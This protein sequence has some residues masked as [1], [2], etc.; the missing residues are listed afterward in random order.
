MWA[1]QKRGANGDLPTFF[2]LV[3]GFGF[4][5]HKGHDEQRNGTR[6]GAPRKASGASG[7]VLR[8]HSEKGGEV[9][10][11]VDSIAFSK[12]RSA[13]RLMAANAGWRA[14]TTCAPT[15]QKRGTSGANVA[16]A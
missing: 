10:D 12:R 14:A 8:Q 2:V 4:D 16:R 11:N 3:T 7:D 5:K 1:V 13:T 6:S 15:N 9:C